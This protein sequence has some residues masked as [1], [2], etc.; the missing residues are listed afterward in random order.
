MQD[1]TG[2]T[3]VNMDFTAKVLLF[4]FYNLTWT[5]DSGLTHD[6]VVRVGVKSAFR[7][8]GPLY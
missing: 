3:F 2:H 4:F 6:T 5:R 1:V 7:R 8:N